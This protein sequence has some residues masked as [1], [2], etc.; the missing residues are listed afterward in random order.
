VRSSS[1]TG[2]TACTER[3]VATLRF[4]VAESQAGS[5]R[6]RA[7][8]ERKEVGTRSLAE[9]LLREGA[10]TVDG[11]SQPKSHRLSA[12]ARVEVSLPEGSHGL[13]PE[14]VTVRTMYDDEHLVVVDK[15]A[16]MTVH[17]GAGAS[18]GTLAAQ[19]LS[20]GATGGEDPERPGI[21]HRLDRDTSGLLVVARSEGAYGALQR[22]IRE[23]EV[24]RRY[25]AL[26]RGRPR[27]RSGRIEAPIGRDRR[28]PT[29]RSLD[30]DEPR[31]AVTRFEVLE[32]LPDRALLDVRL[33]TGRTHQV[34]VHLAAIELP[35]SGDPTYGVKRDLGLERQF[36]HA[37]ALRFAHPVTGD[38]IDLE[39]PLPADL[40]AALARARDS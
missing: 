5:R 23:R 39:S 24:E 26:V 12:G 40:A 21:V 27:S 28:D 11:V 8:A 35:V 38:D 18:R 14:A 17:P 3:A 25:L 22:A 13:Q 19:L 30:T 4:S 1:L 2:R 33:E 31:D 37:H 34:R 29:R 16:G 36:L 6:D 9:R 7:L 20:L 32:L 15:P 10:V